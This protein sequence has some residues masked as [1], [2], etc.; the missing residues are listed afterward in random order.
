M[1]RNDARS[2]Q[3]YHKSK[4]PEKAREHEKGKVPVLNAIFHS[5][6]P[7]KL[8]TGVIK[9]EPSSMT[10]SIPSTIAFSFRQSHR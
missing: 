6:R 8:S 3:G 4:E 5:I 7:S 10:T 2:Y 1:D 9:I